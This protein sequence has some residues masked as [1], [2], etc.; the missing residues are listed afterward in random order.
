MVMDLP[1]GRSHL[2]EAGGL[3]RLD[4]SCWARTTSAAA[5]TRRTALLN[6]RNLRMA[7]NPSESKD[8]KRVWRWRETGKQRPIA[9]DQRTAIKAS[10]QRSGIGHRCPGKQ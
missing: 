1:P 9:G 7:V 8:S 4:L 6:M 10:E 5:V 2:A 3:G